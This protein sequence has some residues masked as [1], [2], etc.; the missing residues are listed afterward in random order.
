[1]RINPFWRNL[2]ILAL[3]ALAI[4]LLNAETALATATV[5]L[6][7]AFFIAVAVVLYFFWRDFGRREIGTWSDRAQGVFYGA[8]ALLV[9]DVGWWV[10]S[11]PQGRNALI[12]IVVAAICAYVGVRTWR[13]QRR[14]S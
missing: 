14:Y 9:V 12:S 10:V 2:A 3:I 6:R 5:L 8:C 7:V 11:A 13:D 4:V 1:M